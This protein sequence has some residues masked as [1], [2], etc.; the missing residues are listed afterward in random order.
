[1]LS[2]VVSIGSC[3]CLSHVAGPRSC[4]WVISQETLQQGRFRCRGYNKQHVR[5]VF[6]LF[7][8]SVPQKWFESAHELCFRFRPIAIKVES[9]NRG[10]GDGKNLAFST[11]RSPRKTRGL[12]RE[13]SETKNKMHAPFPRA[14][15]C[16]TV[17]YCVDICSGGSFVLLCHALLVFAAPVLAIGGAR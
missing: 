13:N 9:T 2:F 4:H 6:V 14:I 5:P 8:L 11:D 1:M 17:L 10:E 15:A 3:I 12:G 16:P 7:F